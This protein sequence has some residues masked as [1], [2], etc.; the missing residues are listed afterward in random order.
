MIS[1][2]GSDPQL[3]DFDHQETLFKDIVKNASNIMEIRMLREAILSSNRRDAFAIRVYEYSV[4][5][6]L[7]AGDYPECFKSLTQLVSNLYV[8]SGNFTIPEILDN[9]VKIASTAST[10]NRTNT[11]T[12]M[13]N[14]LALYLL[15]L[16][17]L[18]PNLTLGELQLNLKRCIAIAPDYKGY[19]IGIRWYTAI[20]ARDF[21]K[22]GRIYA[23]ADKRQCRL[24][25]E[26]L[27]TIRGDL[28]VSLTKSF[29]TLPI[30]IFQSYLLLK[31]ELDTMGLESKDGI[32][33]LK[34]RKSR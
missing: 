5:R 31:S 1:R 28:L 12:D 2:G 24:L 20:K 27:K 16:T 14:S 3:L 34:K 21:V 13:L 17:C 33:T 32:V 15:Y 10:G 4:Q 29:Y 9:Q 26:S 22:L 11:P 8:A 19:D 7:D 18:V 6:C 30:P 23:D 25:D